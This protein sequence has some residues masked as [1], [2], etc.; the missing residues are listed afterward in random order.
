MTDF[1]FETA[2]LKWVQGELSM[3]E[4]KTKLIENG[5]NIDNLP[6]QFRNCS[7][8]MFKHS[9]MTLDDRRH[10]FRVMTKNT[11]LKEKYYN[12]IH[13]GFPNETLMLELLQAGFCWEAGEEFLYRL[14]HNKLKVHYKLKEK[15]LSQVFTVRVDPPLA[16][17][18]SGMEGKKSQYIRKLI[19][20]DIE[21]GDV[22]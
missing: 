13:G 20:K 16:K 2:F 7:D 5:Y 19:K 18:L 8:I 6:N 21:R 17:E 1:N 14:R 3:Q 15:K 12:K 9:N 22:W 10:Q 4:I 11:S